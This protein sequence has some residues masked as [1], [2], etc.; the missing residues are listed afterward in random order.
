MKKHVFMKA[1]DL[2]RQIKNIDMLVKFHKEKSHYTLGICVIE[3]T[4]MNKKYLGLG[5]YAVMLPEKYQKKVSEIL[6]EYK[7]E[8][9]QEFKKL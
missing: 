6:N 9:E 3:D 7:K 8:L 5:D 4:E 1:D 2:N